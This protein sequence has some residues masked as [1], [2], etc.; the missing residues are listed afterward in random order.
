MVKS[1]HIK[2]N[3]AT[4]LVVSL[5]FAAVL[6]VMGSASAA[7]DEL[8][9]MVPAESLFCVRINNFDISRYNFT[10]GNFLP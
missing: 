5:V 3:I 1:K 6:G 10:R 9:G 7:G 2:N 8:F 4:G